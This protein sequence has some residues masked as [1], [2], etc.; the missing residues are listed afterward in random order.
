[1]IK[2]LRFFVL[3]MIIIVLLYSYSWKYIA[4]RLVDVTYFVKHLLSCFLASYLRL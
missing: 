4:V 2:L 3:I 1:M